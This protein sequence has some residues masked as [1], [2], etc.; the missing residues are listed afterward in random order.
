[1][2]TMEYIILVFEFVVMLPLLSVSM[3]NSLFLVK[4]LAWPYSYGNALR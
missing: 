2:T 1:M 4:C 3:T